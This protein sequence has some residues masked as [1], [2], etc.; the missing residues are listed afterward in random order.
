MALRDRLHS[1][2]MGQVKELENQLIPSSSSAV[3]PTSSLSPNRRGVASSSPFA[4]D[5][6]F[7]SHSS[8]SSSTLPVNPLPPHSPQSR[9]PPPSSP[10]SAPLPLSPYSR[11]ST[12]SPALST[13]TPPLSSLAVSAASSRAASF[14]L[15]SPED[16]RPGSVIGISSVPPSPS[17][18]PNT[19]LPPSHYFYPPTQY[20]QPQQQ[21]LQQPQYPPSHPYLHHYQPQFSSYPVHIPPSI[22]S[23]SPP[24]PVAT[25]LH[26]IPPARSIVPSSNRPPL[27]PASPSI[28]SSS[29][30]ARYPSFLAPPPIVIP[31]KG[32]YRGKGVAPPPSSSHPPFINQTGSTSTDSEGERDGGGGGGSNSDSGMSNHRH[33]PVFAPPAP[34]VER[35]FSGKGSFFNEMR[36]MG[37]AVGDFLLLGYSIRELKSSFPSITLQDY[38]QQGFGIEQ[39]KE[40][41]DYTLLDFKVVGC[42]LAALKPFFTLKE[43]YESGYSLRELKNAGFTPQ[44]F[45]AIGLEGSP[46]NVVFETEV[47]PLKGP[48]LQLEQVYGGGNTG[49]SGFTMGNGLGDRRGGKISG[50]NSF[51]SGGGGKS[52]DEEFVIMNQSYKRQYGLEGSRILSDEMIDSLLQMIVKDYQSFTLL[53][54]AT[55][56][57]FK[58]RHF[59]SHCDNQGASITIIK[60]AQGYI[61]GGYTSMS[62][63]S[64]DSWV[65]SSDPSAFL[66]TLK[67]PH[68]IPPTKYPI[69]KLHVSRAIFC[70]I[71]HGPLFGSDLEVYPNGT[72]R[73]R[74][75]SCYLDTSGYGQKTF[76]G[77]GD[78]CHPFSI[79][80][81]WRKNY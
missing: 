29:A 81:I 74:F 60:D 28:S 12:L 61:F 72:Y 26:P 55:R 70:S 27:P 63:T 58:G 19:A 54:R 62:W 8:T 21:Q 20:Q 10:A 22:P 36:E 45:R 9:T 56:E 35:L 30:L 4:V 44:E 64:P 18:A 5:P 31:A 32:K 71:T 16:S 33:S 17:P 51:R 25:A 57:E 73:V 6:S 50:M 1:K 14:T 65:S 59:H 34:Q 53:Y 77:I 75:P 7:P 24:L 13:S 79:V 80:E 37:F 11:V 48:E 42:S 76:T 3:S 47:S 67:N 52:S 66:F 68:S 15:S 38:L 40:E 78:A 2:A 46:V 43:L 39:L 49:E 41:G 69:K 23:P